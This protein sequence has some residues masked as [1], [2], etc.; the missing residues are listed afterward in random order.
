[1]IE[2]AR[3]VPH[4]HCGLSGRPR[5]A[6]TRPAIRAASAGAARRGTS[7]SAAS[8]LILKLVE[9]PHQT[10]GATVPPAWG[11]LER[12]ARCVPVVRGRGGLSR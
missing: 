3:S 8:P 4:H 11:S 6:S 1:M 7:S 5:R 2:H 9:G 10:R 12:R